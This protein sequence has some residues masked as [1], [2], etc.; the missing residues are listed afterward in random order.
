MRDNIFYNAISESRLIKKKQ[1]FQLLPK[2][3]NNYNS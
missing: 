2:Y 1:S 3:I